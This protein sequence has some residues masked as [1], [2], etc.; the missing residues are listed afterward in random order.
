MNHWL[1]SGAAR[2]D[3][4]LSASV[5]LRILAGLLIALV[6]AF[7]VY[8][9]AWLSDD[10]FISL[11]YAS[12]IL[13]GHGPVFN[14]GDQVQ[15]YTHPLW[16]PIL[17]FGLYIAGDPFYAVAALGV[18][19]T[20]AALTSAGYAI[21]ALSANK[22]HGVL[23]ALL[24]AALLVSS[25]TWRAFQTSGLE[26]GLINL[27][28]VLLVWLVYARPNGAHLLLAGLISLMWLTR[29]D[30]APLLIPLAVVCLYQAWLAKQLPLALA[31]FLPALAWLAFAQ[32]YYGDFLPNTANAKVG[33]F[34]TWWDGARQGIRYVQD[35]IQ[36]EPL[37]ALTSA[38]AL[39]GLAVYC[40]SPRKMALWLGLC[41]SLLYV[42][43]VGG[44]FM[45][46]RF[47][48]TFFVAVTTFG[49]FELATRLPKRLYAPHHYGMAM[50][51]SA[52]VVLLF[53]L[54]RPPIEAENSGH[55]INSQRAFYSGLSLQSYREHGEP[56]YR[57]YNMAWIDELRRY[58][59]HCGSLTIHTATVGLISY[60]AGDKVTII[61]TLGLN[62][63]FIANLPRENLIGRPRIGH[64]FKYIPISYLAQRGDI[65]IFEGWD[66]AIRDL[67]CDFKRWTE[68]Y[69][70]SDQLYHPLQRIPLPESAPALP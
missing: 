61:D 69:V 59:D 25:E 60:Y 48:L 9:I 27:W 55:G 5:W 20:F 34:E 41:L 29:P 62:D 57:F 8:Q 22:V 12:N 39:T 21:M 3:Q 35:W 30:L 13:A 63:A 49:A 67:D 14:V 65:S 26:N 31:G 44:D 10:G 51:A 11:R 68:H 2:V 33:V 23:V 4:A 70:D 43:M 64:P 37:P 54:A 47:L 45:R 36:H 53:F 18:L 15:G 6:P 16:L 1:A 17:T 50:I 40:R 19:L 24:L 38:V 58:A 46:G 32:L 28:V 42:V 66:Q 7:S 56:R 52:T